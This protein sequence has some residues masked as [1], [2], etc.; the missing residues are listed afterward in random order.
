VKIL[1]SGG[2]RF[3]DYKLVDRAMDALHRKKRIRFLITGG[4]KGAQEMAYYWAVRSRIPAILTVPMQPD[5]TGALDWSRWNRD[6]LKRFEVD[7]LVLFPG[8]SETEHL[9]EL[10]EDMGRRVWRVPRS[11]RG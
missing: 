10:A 6:I 5:L 7:G 11:W 1:V 2:Q 9:A 3:D 4:L 8:R